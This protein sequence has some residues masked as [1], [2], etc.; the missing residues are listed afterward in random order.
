MR[1]IIVDTRRPT[2]TLKPLPSQPS[3]SPQ[4][5]D[6]HVV[7]IEWDVHDENLDPNSIVLEGRYI[8][9]E[10]RW[11]ILNRNPEHKSKQEWTIQ[12]HQKLEV[13]LRALDKAGHSSEATAILAA[14]GST[15]SRPSHENE[16]SAGATTAAKI[17]YLNTKQIRLKFKVQNTGPSGVKNLELYHTKDRLKWEKKLIPFEQVKTEEV[18]SFDATDDGLYGFIVVAESGSGMIE[19]PP[20]TNTEPRVWVKV[21]TKPPEIK[22]FDVRNDMGNITFSWHVEDENLTDKPIVLEWAPNKGGEWKNI[23][24]LEAGRGGAGRYTWVAPKDPYLF[25][26]RM[27][28]LDKAMNAAEK[29]IEKEIMVD[30]N[31]PTVDITAVEPVGK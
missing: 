25:Y 20:Q 10:K 18:I 29:V 28:V 21:D 8:G 30:F 9:G 26:V 5:P 11:A 23:N 7:G 14:S 1:T 6:G 4:Y 13:R 22:Q 17:T 12:P 2:I 16:P 3:R 15:V 27:R 24:L 31:R 19:P